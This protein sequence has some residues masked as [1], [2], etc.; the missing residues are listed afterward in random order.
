M[1][2]DLG[3]DLMVENISAF[4][5]MFPSGTFNDWLAQLSPQDITRAIMSSQRG[6]GIWRELWDSVPQSGQMNLR[7]EA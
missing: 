3:K 7:R 1:G 6:T 5:A 4:R 2:R